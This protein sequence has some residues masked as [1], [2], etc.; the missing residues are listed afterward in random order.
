MCLCVCVC[1]FVCVCVHLCVTEIVSDLSSTVKEWMDGHII[2]CMRSFWNVYTNKL[3]G[4]FMFCCWFVVIISLT[5][6]TALCR[7]LVTVITG[8]RLNVQGLLL[9]S[10]C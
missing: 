6:W 4:C 3:K 8:C 2:A 10:L 7:P 5:P 1:V 9:E